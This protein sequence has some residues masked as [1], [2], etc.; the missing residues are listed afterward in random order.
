MRTIESEG[1]KKIK[2]AQGISPD[3]GLGQGAT[4]RDIDRAFGEPRPTEVQP[5]AKGSDGVFQVTVDWIDLRQQMKNDW[6]QD[7][8]PEYQNIR[9]P[10]DLEFQFDYDFDPDAQYAFQKV[11]IVN[12]RSV[13]IYPTNVKPPVQPIAM[14]EDPLKSMLFEW[15]EDEMKEDVDA[16]TEFED[17][18]PPPYDTREEQMGLR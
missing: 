8:P 12:P 7:V 17:V 4:E 16:H 9:G 2:E 14:V 3:P 13:G 11:T 15:F 18:N 1:Y 6:K 5:A 10:V